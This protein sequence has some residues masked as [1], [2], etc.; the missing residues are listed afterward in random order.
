[1]LSSRIAERGLALERMCWRALV[2]AWRAF[3]LR[4]MRLVE[5]GVFPDDIETVDRWNDSVSVEQRAH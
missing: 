1:M 4:V 3:N 5:D 2:A